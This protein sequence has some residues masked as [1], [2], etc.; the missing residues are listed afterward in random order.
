MLG[1]ATS[2]QTLEARMPHIEGAFEQVA[3]RLDSMENR[4]DGRFAAID[5]RFAQMDQRCHTFA[6]VDDV[7]TGRSAS[8]DDTWTTDDRSRFF[9][10]TERLGCF[11]IEDLHALSLNRLLPPSLRTTLVGA[12]EFKSTSWIATILAI[13][14]DH[15]LT[16]AGR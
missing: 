13:L 7:S 15:Q 8:S 14:F 5:H 2:V 16:G 9:S 6:Q 1:S 12:A 11:R 4:F 10:I 3:K